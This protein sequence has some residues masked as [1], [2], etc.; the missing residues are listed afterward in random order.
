MNANDKRERYASLNDDAFSKC[1]YLCTSINNLNP[2]LWYFYSDKHKGICIEF[3]FPDDVFDFVKIKYD[4]KY[5]NLNF[6][7][8]CNQAKEYL[9]HKSEYW[10]FEKEIRLFYK[11][12]VCVDLEGYKGIYDC[13]K[14]IKSLTIGNDVEYHTLSKYVCKTIKQFL[15][16]KC[17]YTVLWHEG[18]G[19]VL[20]NKSPVLLDIIRDID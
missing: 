12:E 8:A 7:I 9:S 4:N 10:G 15:E 19:S 1:N 20:E 16:N 14:Y 2:A 11:G 5:Q 17:L 3:D 13:V 18:I 6:N